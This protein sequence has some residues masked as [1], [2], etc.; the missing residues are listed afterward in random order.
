MRLAVYD[1]LGREVV[2]LADAPY[3]AGAHALTFNAA[4]LP[5][6]LYFARLS[7]LGQTKLHR[8]LLVK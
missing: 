6:G 2:L 3:E 1:V 8:M 5:T 7:A 4:D